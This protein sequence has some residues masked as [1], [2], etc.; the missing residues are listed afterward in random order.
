MEPNQNEKD[1][2]AKLEAL[3]QEHNVTFKVVVSPVGRVSKFIH[4]VTQ[5]IFIL[6]SAVVIVPNVIPQPI[7]DNK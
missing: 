6:S 5:K 4:W 1:F 3:M 2:K 7:T